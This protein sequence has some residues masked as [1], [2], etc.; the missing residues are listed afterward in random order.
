[1]SELMGILCEE[2]REILA[3]LSKPYDTSH[4]QERLTKLSVYNARTGE[5]LAEAEYL[6]AIEK[7]NALNELL[8]ADPKM[9]ANQQKVMLEARCAESIKVVRLIERANRATVHGGEIA[10]S[11]AYCEKENMSLTRKGY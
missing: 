1:M 5:M 10:I 9:G 11:Q 6:L 3:Y 2:A 7:G 4:L 8:S